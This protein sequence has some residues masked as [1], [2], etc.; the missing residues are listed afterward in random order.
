[1]SLILCHLH[2]D[3]VIECEGKTLGEI[4]ELAKRFASDEIRNGIEVGSCELV[5][6]V[7]QLPAGWR[8]SLPYRDRCESFAPA[9]TCRQILEAKS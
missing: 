8:S 9:L 7:E 5:T 4:G 3:V 1:M 2:L 6:S